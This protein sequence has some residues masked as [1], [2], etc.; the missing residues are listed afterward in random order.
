MTPAIKNKKLRALACSRPFAPA[1]GYSTFGVRARERSRHTVN[2][3]EEYHTRAHFRPSDCRV[4][5][6]SGSRNAD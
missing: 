2:D 3:D 4:S 5:R 6:Q 1:A